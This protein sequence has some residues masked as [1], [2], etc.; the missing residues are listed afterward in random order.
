MNGNGGPQ[1][2]PASWWK[3]QNTFS[4]AKTHIHFH[5]LCLSLLPTSAVGGLQRQLERLSR[6]F[7]QAT[8]SV[9]DLRFTSYHLHGIRRALSNFHDCG[10][11]MP[12][13]NHHDVKKQCT[14]RISFLQ[15]VV[16]V[17]DQHF[18]SYGFHGVRR[19][20]NNCR[21]CSILMSGMNQHDAGYPFLIFRWFPFVHVS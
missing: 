20:L 10:I 6:P 21:D 15:A 16:S 12:C 7:L 18:K 9:T 14:Q 17:A 19:A 11:L 1:S 8:V 4:R 13:M 2:R 5:S 3:L